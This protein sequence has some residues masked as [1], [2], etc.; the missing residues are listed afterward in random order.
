MTCPHIAQAIQFGLDSLDIVI[1]GY[2]WGTKPE[3]MITLMRLN[4]FFLGVGLNID[5]P[6]FSRR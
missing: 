2:P 1:I 3:F 6:Q 4:N 5:N